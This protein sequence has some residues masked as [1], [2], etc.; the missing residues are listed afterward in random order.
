MVVVVVA[1]ICVDINRDANKIRLKRKHKDNIAVNW[2]RSI[3][4]YKEITN[5]TF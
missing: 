5:L 1:Y 3:F 2:S 4:Q